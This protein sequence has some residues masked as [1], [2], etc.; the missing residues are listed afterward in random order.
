M[1]TENSAEKSNFI[2]RPPRIQ[3]PLPED[4]IPVPPP[5]DLQMSNQNLLQLL[6]PLVTIIGYALVGAS[7]G[8][9]NLLFMI[10]MGISVVATSGV[11]L[12]SYLKEREKRLEVERAYTN[13]LRA[14]RHLLASKHDEQRLYYLHTHPNIQLINDIGLGVEITRIGQRLW[15]R[16]PDDHDFCALRLGIGDIPS[17]VVCELESTTNNPSPSLNEAQQLVEDSKVVTDAPIIIHLRPTIDHSGT[18]PKEIPATHSLGIAGD[19]TA[20]T[21]FTRALLMQFTALHTPLDT[22]LF[23]IGADTAQNRWQWATELPHTNGALRQAEHTCFAPPLP[24]GADPKK[25]T[26]TYPKRFWAMVNKELSDRQLRLE[27]DDASNDMSLPFLLV[28]VDMMDGAAWLEDAVSESAVSLILSQGQTLGA[29]IIFLTPQASKIPSDCLG[30]IELQVAGTGYR[31]Q[32]SEVGLNA[33][34]FLGVTEGAESAMAEAFAKAIKDRQIRMGYGA[35]L[36]NSLSLLDLYEIKR[37]E[38]LNFIENW[39]KSLESGKKK[40]DWLRVKIG[41]K[42]GGDIQEIYFHQD[43]DGVHGMVAG[44]T[45]SGKSELLLT[46]IAGLAINY[47]PRIVNFVLVDYK[48]GAAFEP[49]RHLPHVVDI[50]TN[51]DGKAVERMFVAIDEEMRRRGKILA[52]YDV[53][54]I[55]EYREKGYHLEKNDKGNIIEPFPHLF[56]VVDEFAEMINENKEYKARFDSITRL[57]RAI[58][59]NLLLATQRPTGVVSDQMRANMKLKI[60]L[61]VETPDDSR[62]LLGRG[63]ATFL[64]SNIP[65]R[66]YLQVGKD[67]LSLIQVARAGG[68][69]QPPDVHSGS[70]PNIVFESDLKKQQTPEDEKEK[71]TIVKLVVERSITLAE[72]HSVK[73]YKPWPDPLP[74]LLPLN[75]PVNAKHLRT[76]RTKKDNRIVLNP[77]VLVWMSREKPAMQE[78]IARWK[79][80]SA[81]WSQEG[82]LTATIG[83]IDLPSQAHQRL[84]DLDLTAGPIALFGAGGWGKTTFLK[85]LVLAFSAKLSPQE[86]QFYALDFAR[87]G[88]NSLEGLPHLETPVDVTQEARVERLLRM[89]ATLISDREQLMRTDGSLLLYNRN[90]PDAIQP[91]VVVMVDNFAEFK[92]TYE[93]QLT[94]FVQLVRAGRA[95]GV[96]FVVTADQTGSIPNKLYSLFTQRLTLKLA[97]SGEYQSIVGRAAHLLTETPGRGAISIER[98]PREFHL[99]VPTRLIPISKKENTVKPKSDIDLSTALETVYEMDKEYDKYFRELAEAMREAWGD[100]QTAPEVSALAS[101]I[102]LDSLWK[103]PFTRRGVL[104]APVGVRDIDRATIGIDLQNHLLVIGAQ[105]SGKTTT[106]QSYIVSLARLVSPQEVVFVLID[107]KR[108]LFAYDEGMYHFKNI[109]HVLETVSEVEELDELFKRL[110]AEYDLETQAKLRDYAQKTQPTTPLFA[111]ERPKRHLIV[112]IDNYDD[113]ADFER[114]RQ[115]DTVAE[116]VRRYRD[117]VHLV[118]CGSPEIFKQRDNLLKRAETSR[119]AVVLGSTEA[120]PSVGGRVAYNVNRN[121]LPFGRGFRVK[122]GT[123]ELLQFGILRQDGESMASLLDREIRSL[124]DKYP[125]AEWYY[126]GTMATYDAAIENAGSATQPEYDEVTIDAPVSDEMEEMLK[127]INAEQG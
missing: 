88:L 85:T 99:G 119:Y 76:E 20:V 39:S 79:Q 45:G 115:F 97:D 4:V 101:Q 7:G 18:S 27:D 106:L 116:L 43:Y 46:L 100:G 33:K 53:K 65:G 38:D 70:K 121:E 28:V 54:H 110:Q 75:L 123:T 77:D 59:V 118:I 32:Y 73:Q 72:T 36:T 74:E 62:E 90:H 55:V 3:P 81:D 124:K 69:Y 29:S 111:P 120:L 125:H 83:L 9:R 40:A 34:R 109:P 8:G 82:V 94:Q 51:L 17:R 35:D 14:V 37:I 16:R 57:G 49:F 84:L 47:D 21:N 23:V 93:Q 24:K 56:I 108:K 114:N 127:R 105:V 89:L 26:R 52:D 126:R 86:I 87:G 102:P 1:V 58:G 10:P 15:E 95:F 92:D 63:D 78:R 98:E 60:C 61:R 113:I 80:N 31:F 66:A 12:Y 6:L 50:V 5:P 91:A 13:R 25:E 122:E 22:K 42:S 48:G 96:Y 19:T 30:V 2:E 71:P 67:A 117:T 68:E 104:S 11:A 64:P 41:A 44:T 107:T 112:V 103:K